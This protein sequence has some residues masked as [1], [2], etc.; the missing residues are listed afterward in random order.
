MTK[1][2]IFD[3]YFIE[4]RKD[5]ERMPMVEFAPYWDLTLNNWYD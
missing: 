3:A 4:N 5:V 2:E 1:R